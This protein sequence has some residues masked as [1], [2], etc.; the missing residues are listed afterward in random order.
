MIAIIFRSNVRTLVRAYWT[1]ILNPAYL[2]SKIKPTRSDKFVQIV[3]CASR[4]ESAKSSLL[5]SCA[6]NF[7]TTNVI[8]YDK[9]AAVKYCVNNVKNLDMFVNFSRKCQGPRIDFT[10]FTGGTFLRE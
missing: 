10:F 9:N 7:F 2:R 5:Q 6:S 1:F 8:L 4:E 3:I